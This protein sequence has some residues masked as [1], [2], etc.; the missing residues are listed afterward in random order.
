MENDQVLLNCA[1]ALFSQ[2]GYDAVSVREIVE[3]AGVTKPTLYHYFSSKRGLL[4]ALVNR[5]AGLLLV[6]VTPAADFH[7]DLVLTLESTVRAYFEFAQVHTVFYR[8]HLACYFSPPESEVNQA[9]RHFIDQQTAM[10]ENLFKRAAENHGNLRGKQGRLAVSLLGE[11]NALI[12]LHLNGKLDLSDA[13][14]FQTI[15]QFMYG[16]FS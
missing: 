1:L 5:E 15:H 3:A 4:D 12:G 2:R 6:R 9:M 14:V 13:I 11:I 7:G 8:F 16:I 10:L